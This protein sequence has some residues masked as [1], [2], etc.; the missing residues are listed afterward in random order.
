MTLEAII[1]DAYEQRATINPTSARQR[2]ALP[3]QQMTEQLDAGTLSVAEKSVG[4]VDRASV[5]QEGS[6]AVVSSE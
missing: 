5:G 2:C 3:S 6:A 4:K 1:I